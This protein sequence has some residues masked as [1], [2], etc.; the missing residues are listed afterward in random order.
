ME[1]NNSMACGLSVLKIFLC[2]RNY[3]PAVEKQKWMITCIFRTEN[4][5]KRTSFGT[6][7][8]LRLERKPKNELYFLTEVIRLYLLYYEILYIVRTIHFPDIIYMFK[9]L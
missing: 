2:V 3:K 5:P 9:Y 1:L 8:P 7:K 4:E 6:T